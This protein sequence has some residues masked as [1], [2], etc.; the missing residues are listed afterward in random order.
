MANKL[1]VTFVAVA[2]I[3][4]LYGIAHRDREFDKFDTPTEMHGSCFIP[5]GKGRYY[6]P[7]MLCPPWSHALQFCDQRTGA[8]TRPACVRNPLPDPIYVHAEPQPCTVEN[9]LGGYLGFQYLKPR[10]EPTTCLPEETL[11]MCRMYIESYSSLDFVLE[12][13]VTELP[14]AQCEELVYVENL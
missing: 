10:R 4:C 3:G 5:E 8:W 6:A 12:T 1:L 13:G 9:T 2:I 11:H 14:F 7:D